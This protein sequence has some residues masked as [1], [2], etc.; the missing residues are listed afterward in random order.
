MRGIKPTV[1][2]NEVKNLEATGK[3]FAYQFRILRSRLE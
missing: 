2:L 1:I 3:A